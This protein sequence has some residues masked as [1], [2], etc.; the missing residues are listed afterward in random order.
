MSKKKFTFKQ[1]CIVGEK[2]KDIRRDLLTIAEFVSESYPVAESARIS[3]LVKKLGVV[4]SGL[5]S[6]M[7]SEGHKG[8]STLIYYGESK[9]DEAMDYSFIDSLSKERN[10]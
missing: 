10:L 7:F 4:R 8:A 2:L 9:R 5:D 6:L 1:H 3:S